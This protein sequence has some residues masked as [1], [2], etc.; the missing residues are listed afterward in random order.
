MATDL[1]SARIALESAQMTQMRLL[2]GAAMG[3]PWQTAAD[4]RGVTDPP[5][6]PGA[7]IM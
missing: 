2:P 4:A 7:F 1:A 5:A 3:L 6:K